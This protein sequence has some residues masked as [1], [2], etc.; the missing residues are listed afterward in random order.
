M[1]KVIELLKEWKKTGKN[2][3][4]NMDGEWVELTSAE[5]ILWNMWFMYVQCRN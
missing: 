4:Y 3:F 5:D 1:E 2:C